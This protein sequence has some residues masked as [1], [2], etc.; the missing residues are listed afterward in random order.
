MRSGH[1]CALIR[2]AGG[3]FPG[4]SKHFLSAHPPISTSH[5]DR[6]GQTGQPCGKRVHISGCVCLGVRPE[7]VAAPGFCL[8]VPRSYGGIG[9]TL[10]S[11][12]QW[13]CWE[14]GVRVDGASSGVFKKS[15]CPVYGKGQVDKQWGWEE[16]CV[17]PCYPRMKAGTPASAG[18]A[19][20]GLTS[21]PTLRK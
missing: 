21:R 6:C 7:R 18:G 3:L 4:P 14:Q 2:G 20:G 13:V 5:C 17:L 11:C 16:R 8:C 12:A 9:S 15:P 1:N 19:G 10:G